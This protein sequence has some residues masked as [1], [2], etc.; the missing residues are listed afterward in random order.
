M[1]Q[2][3]LTTSHEILYDADCLRVLGSMKSGVIDTV[4]A[5]PPF[6]I[7]KDYKNGYDEKAAQTEYL[8]WCR[9]WDWNAAAS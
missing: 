5:D 1:M 3:F 8:I 2:P 7:G 6:N 4:F 9:R